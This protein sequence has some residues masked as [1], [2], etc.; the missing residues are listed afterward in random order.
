MGSRVEL[1]EQI[2]R[3]RE[4]EG[5]VDAC[6]GAQVRGASPD[7][8]NER[9][10]VGPG[11]ACEVLTQR[12]CREQTDDAASRLTMPTAIRQDSTTRTVT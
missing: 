9:R 12:H 2:R 6:V 7:G 10:V 5:A 3:D 1:F 11:G 4:F 8:Q